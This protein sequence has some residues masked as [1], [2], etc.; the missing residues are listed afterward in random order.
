MASD[1][2]YRP[3]IRYE[4]ARSIASST[5]QTDFTNNQYLLNTWQLLSSAQGFVSSKTPSL[6]PYRPES[7]EASKLCSR[8]AT[9]HANANSPRRIKAACRHLVHLPAVAITLVALSLSWRDVFWETPSP[10]AESKLGALQF[11]A[12]IHEMLIVLSLSRLAYDRVQQDLL[13]GPHGVPLGFLSAGTQVDSAEYIFSQRFWQGFIQHHLSLRRLGMTLFLLLLFVLATVAG[14]ASAIIMIPSLDWW[15]MS[16]NQ[17][18]Q[19]FVRTLHLPVFPLTVTEDYSTHR[20]RSSFGTI[21]RYFQDH[22]FNTG[23]F[24]ARPINISIGIEK[25]QFQRQIIGKSLPCLNK[26]HSYYVSSALPVFIA[27]NLAAM[28]QVL[29]LIPRPWDLAERV[30]MKEHIGSGSK[31]EDALKTFQ[32]QK[33]YKPLVQVECSST[34]AEA[35]DANLLFF[36]YDNLPQFNSSAE[37][38]SDWRL[39]ASVQ[40]LLRNESSRLEPK[41]DSSIFH[42][43]DMDFVGSTRPSIGAAWFGRTVSGNESLHLCTIDARWVPVQ[44]WIDPSVDSTIQDDSADLTA[45]THLLPKFTYNPIHITKNWASSINTINQA[46]VDEASPQVLLTPSDYFFRRCA[47]S[48]FMTA[49]TFDEWGTISPNMSHCLGSQLGPWIA[50][51]LGNVQSDMTTFMKFPVYN[52]DQDPA[53]S[54]PA[55]W[56]TWML[57]LMIKQDSLS[58]PNLNFPSTEQHGWHTDPSN[59][60]SMMPFYFTAQQYGYGYG[61]RSV[62]TY[63]AA[64]ILLLHVLLVLVHTSHILLRGN[65]VWLH[66]SDLT[67]L[68]WN[69]CPDRQLRGTSFGMKDKRLWGKIVRLASGSDGQLELAIDEENGSTLARGASTVMDEC[70]RGNSTNLQAPTKPSAIQKEMVKREWH[71]RSRLRISEQDPHRIGSEWI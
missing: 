6:I 39:P 14:P 47:Q 31:A 13:S 8:V 15:P 36:P 38:D 48:T 45:I 11:L 27:Y 22:S 49:M 42:W 21:F 54:K 5:N 7:A 66:M 25:S 53:V 40:L 23:D 60:T 34:G 44:V 69:S 17:S 16:L 41:T 50:E 33:I 26:D 52:S 43:V 55:N 68:A 51:S 63:V 32:D 37:S 29:R 9:H 70:H 12:K 56:T 30:Q 61:W 35:L 71:Q 67:I 4:A 46:S 64:A 65:N 3:D 57:N 28:W 24:I 58:L 1:R 2:A 62:I 20:G 10:G 18:W 19:L 59:D